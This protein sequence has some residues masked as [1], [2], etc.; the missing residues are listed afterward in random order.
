M[1]AEASDDNQPT[2]LDR[3]FEP[4]KVI[5]VDAEGRTHHFVADYDREYTFETDGGRVYIVGDDGLEHVEDLGERPV[6]HW[7]Q[8]IDEELCGWDDV[9]MLSVDLGA[10]DGELRGDDR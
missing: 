9:H 2:A 1:A 7:I 3:W 4:H 6:A 10:I 8:F 5:G